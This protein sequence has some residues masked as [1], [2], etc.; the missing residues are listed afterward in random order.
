MPKLVRPSPQPST[1]TKSGLTRRRGA[2]LENAL[3]EAAWE[4]LQTTGYMRMTME[5][6]A[7]RAGTSRAVIYRRWRNRHEL[8]IAALRH[9]QPL[10]SDRIPDTGSLREDTITILRR[11][12]SR[13]SATGPDTVVGLLADLL[14]DEEA[15][16]H[17]LDQLSRGGAE[18]MT[19]ILERAAAR[20]EAR[21]EIGPRIARLPL[22][23]LRHELILTHQP[24]SQR[25]LEE[26]VD[27]IFL[28]LV[29]PVTLH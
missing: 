7:D 18:V 19:A 13:I 28:P 25:T 2:R 4:E 12:S 21:D 17:V 26:I 23:L 14:A 8:A 15:S 3:L 1:E 24:P 11:A 6:V 9:H 5:R 10:F 22:D 20:G 27:D 16:H 29:R